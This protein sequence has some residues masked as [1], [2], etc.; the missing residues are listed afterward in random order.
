[1]I[2]DFD[3]HIDRRGS[4]ALAQDGFDGYLFRDG[5]NLNYRSR[6]KT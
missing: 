2:H 6:G 4:N 5:A 1:M 3:A